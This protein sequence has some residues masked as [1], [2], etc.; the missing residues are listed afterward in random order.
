MKDIQSITVQFDIGAK[1]AAELWAVAGGET[2]QEALRRA[3]RDAIGY[4]IWISHMKRAGF[5]IQAVREEE[6]QTTVRELRS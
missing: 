2:E 4:Y 5:R 6:H 1:L 3:L